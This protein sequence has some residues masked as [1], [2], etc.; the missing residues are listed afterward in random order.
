MRTVLVVGVG[1]LVV[2]W[3]I[4][5]LDPA[6]GGRDIGLDTIDR[7]EREAGVD[8]NRDGF[9]ARERGSGAYQPPTL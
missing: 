9:R 6:S 1:L 7:L 4:R 5:A 2:V 8:L 3:V